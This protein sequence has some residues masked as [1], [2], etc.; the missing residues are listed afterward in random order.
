M[1]YAII[2]KVRETQFVEE[3][4][5]CFEKLW[6]LYKTEVSYY[7][8][9]LQCTLFNLIVMYLSDKILLENLSMSQYVP[10]VPFLCVYRIALIWK[11][12]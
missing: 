9:A 7:L 1:H 11:K 2:Q 8:G 6:L 3:A 5:K 10:G 4:W 12:K